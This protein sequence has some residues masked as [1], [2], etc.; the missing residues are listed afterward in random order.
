MLL[1]RAGNQ[2][3]QAYVET[4]CL[5]DAYS[6]CDLE[7][8]GAWKVYMYIVFSVHSSFGLCVC[9]E[10]IMASAPP[11]EP[12]NFGHPQPPTYEETMKAPQYGYSPT[13][14]PPLYGKM[15]QPACPSSVYPPPQAH[16]PF[17]AE[18]YS[19]TYPLQQSNASGT[20][21]IRNIAFGISSCSFWFT[22][23]LKKVTHQRM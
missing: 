22:Y 17:P 19:Q 13:Q 16:P 15:P 23:L 20:S 7:I 8:K 6:L 18:P 11:M 3:R 1:N 10:Y 2:R 21:P 4:N 12:D 5:T 14:P 9:P